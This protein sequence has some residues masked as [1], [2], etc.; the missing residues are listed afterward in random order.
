LTRLLLA[1]RNPGKLRELA[2]LLR[3]AGLRDLALETLGDHPEVSD[4]EETGRTFDENA[5]LKA[6]F[7]A[8][9]TG[10]W[11]L[12]EDSGLEVSALGGRPGVH[13]ARYAGPE[14]DDE[15]NNARLVRELE[16]VVDRR[17]RYVCIAA[18]A[19]PDG[20]VVAKARG[21]CE[22]TIAGAPRGGGGFGYDPYFVPEEGQQ[23]MAELTAEEKAA[24]SHRGR[25]VRALVPALSQHLVG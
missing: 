13:S 10:L 4:V 8:R 11:S 15:A 19:R 1:T 14:R 20:K 22:G 5:C 6:R 18:L 25:A 17:A 3:E 23:T 16:G 21:T 24:I 7:A 12:G 9:E 2:P